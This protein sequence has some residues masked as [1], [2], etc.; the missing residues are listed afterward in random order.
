MVALSAHRLWSALGSWKN[1]KPSSSPSKLLIPQSEREAEA[2]NPRHSLRVSFYQVLP[3]LFSLR[4]RG[5]AH[6]PPHLQLDFLCKLHVVL[7]ASLPF[8]MAL[9]YLSLSV[10]LVTH[11]SKISEGLCCVR[12]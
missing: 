7:K 9:L 11:S 8:S 6:L 5:A 1:H 12:P 4:Q 2:P 3:S 10:H